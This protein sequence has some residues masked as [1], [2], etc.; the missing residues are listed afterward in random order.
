M[1]REVVNNGVPAVINKK[2]LRDKKKMPL[3]TIVITRGPS[4]HK[5]TATVGNRKVRFGAAGYDDY[6]VHKDIKRRAAYLARH[7]GRENWSDPTTAGFWSRWMLW[8]D[9]PS[10]E[11]NA[12]IIG[13]KLGRRVQISK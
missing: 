5:F 1:L 13:Q 3:P 7:K 9:H 11:A 10:L 6:T 12:R 8:G 2:L 4:P